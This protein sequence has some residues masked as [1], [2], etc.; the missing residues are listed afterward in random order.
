MLDVKASAATEVTA[1]VFVFPAGAYVVPRLTLSRL[2]MSALALR[3]SIEYRARSENGMD[4]PCSC[5]E[6]LPSDIDHARRL[7]HGGS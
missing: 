6:P 3:M 7:S 5:P 4:R 1:G 2:L